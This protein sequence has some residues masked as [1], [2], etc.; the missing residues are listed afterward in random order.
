MSEQGRLDPWPI[1]PS[2]M[3]GDLMRRAFGTEPP[4][5]RVRQDWELRP[6]SRLGLGAVPGSLGADRA[7]SRVEAMGER[8]SWGLVR[9]GALLL[10]LALV[11][12][13]CGG[14]DRTED[15]G[16][17]SMPDGTGAAR[18]RPGGEIVLAVEQWPECLNPVT[19]CANATWLNWSV[20]VH[21][22]PPLMEFDERNRLRASPVLAEAPTAENG[23]TVLNDDGTFT[24]TYRLNPEARWSDGSAITSTDVWFT[25]RAILDTEGSLD[26]IGYD[27]IT[28]ID[29]TDPLT[30]VVT[31]SEAYAPWRI[32]FGRIP[33]RPR[34]R[35]RD[36]HLRT[37]E[38]RDH[39]VGRAVAPAVLEPGPA[40]PDSQ[41]ELLG[42]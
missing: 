8:A 34:V 22:L 36:R 13:A 39:L 9:S 31:F 24:L 33:A 15:A 10:A 1:G 2:A 11:A 16:D 40:H 19:S 26:T 29:H 35:R 41:R 21:L 37:L 4:S 28:G 20:L 18:E 23:G 27:L 14:A 12:A 7:S 17:A 42:A 6:D 32:L 38:R 5:G 30:A 25:W 3:A